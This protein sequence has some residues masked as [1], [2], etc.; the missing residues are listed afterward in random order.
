MNLSMDPFHVA[1]NLSLPDFPYIQERPQTCL[2]FRVGLM[3]PRDVFPVDVVHE[4]IDVG[5]GLRAVINMIRVLV[6]IERQNGTRSG[7]T[8]G[9]VRSPLIDEFFVAM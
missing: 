6:H 2:L 3:Q 4:S 5:G 7:Q 1:P 9:M 8:A